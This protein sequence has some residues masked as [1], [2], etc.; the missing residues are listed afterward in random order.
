MFFFFV[1]VVVWLFLCFI[2]EMTKSFVAFH[3]FFFLDLFLEDAMNALYLFSEIQ[4]SK[5]YYTRYIYIGKHLYEQRNSSSQFGASGSPSRTSFP[6]LP[7]SFS[8]SFNGVALSAEKDDTHSPRLPEKE[9]KRISSHAASV[10][11]KCKCEG[12]RLCRASIV[13]E[14]CHMD[15]K[16]NEVFLVAPLKVLGHRFFCTERKGRKVWEPSFIYPYVRAC[17]VNLAGKVQSRLLFI[18]IIYYYCVCLPKNDDLPESHLGGTKKNKN[19]KTLKKGE[20][21]QQQQKKMKISLPP[22]WRALN[23]ARL[24]TSLCVVWGVESDHSTTSRCTRT[25][26]EILNSTSFSCFL[27]LLVFLVSQ[28]KIKRKDPPTHYSIVFRFCFRPIRFSY[29]IYIFIIRIFIS[30]KIIIIIERL[31][32]VTEAVV[33]EY[34]VFHL[35]HISPPFFPLPQYANATH[36]HDSKTVLQL[37][38]D[39]FHAWRAAFPAVWLGCRKNYRSSR[40]PPVNRDQLGRNGAVEFDRGAR[41]RHRQHFPSP[42]AEAFSARHPTTTAAAAAAAGGGGG[43][44][45]APPLPATPSGARGCALRLSQLPGRDAGPGLQ[46]GVRLP[47]AQ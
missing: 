12:R 45:H 47:R 44:P 13:F 9:G 36:G 28:T 15:V 29:Y 38:S 41:R 5:P 27:L 17:V 34:I 6:P 4:T 23:D 31:S 37:R 16:S 10:C 40:P 3:F 22:F 18:I 24:S 11:R 26:T 7:L 14:L 42:R 20:K 25:Q 1:V 32:P 2:G 8:Y 21:K 30:V 19:G 33:R 35:F 43:V 39:G 46:E